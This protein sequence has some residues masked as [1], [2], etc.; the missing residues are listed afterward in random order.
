V[1]LA[2]E[3]RGYDYFHSDDPMEAARFIVSDAVAL[4]WGT[5]RDRPPG[6][7]TV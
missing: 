3:T 4:L 2:D 7:V 6:L 1:D 5:V